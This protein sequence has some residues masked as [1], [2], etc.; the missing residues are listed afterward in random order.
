MNT[1]IS[2]LLEQLTRQRDNLRS[3]LE[4]DLSAAR[5][6]GRTTLTDLERRDLE[7]IRAL[8]QRIEEAQAEAKRAGTSPV[9]GKLGRQVSTAGQLTPLTL[10]DEELRRLHGAAQREEHC[11]I[12]SRAF[13]TVE[14]FLPG[15]LY[16]Q[17][18]GQQHEGRLL[19]RLP[20][21]AMETASIDFIRH[22][23]TTGAP[24]TVAEGAI[25]N[26]LVL[27][28]DLIT[29]P[30]RKLAAHT[31]TSTEIAQ[32]WPSWNAYVVGELAAQIVDL[33]N[34]QLLNGTGSSPVTD[35]VGFYAT[36]GI[37]TH[38]ASADTGSGV[39]AL[40]S[41]ELGIS[42]LRTG[43][44]LA[45]ADVLVLNPATWSKIRRVKDTQGRF[46][47]Q[48]D[49][50]AA[51]ANSLWGITVVQTTANPVGKALL[52]DSSKFGYVGVPRAI[53]CGPDGQMMI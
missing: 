30:A 34:N 16:G 25:K 1:A 51:E 42:A 28:T 4:A 18:I 23:S 33:E 8:N 27:N 17:V 20:G 32:D 11:R 36:S 48:P 13:S 50:T 7:D 45:V 46:L 10:P 9:S 26:E 31:A 12:D 29:E 47:A 24:S 6:S 5:R 43:S 35:M 2:G 37:L 22:I 15:Q 38:D 41:V 44:A 52:L 14:G 21:V 3:G 19:D 39:T 40:D 49:P 53:R